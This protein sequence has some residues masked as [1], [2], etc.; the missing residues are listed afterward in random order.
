[1]ADRE[2]LL[3]AFCDGCYIT[4]LETRTLK[5]LNGKDIGC[6]GETI[7]LHEWPRVTFRGDILAVVLGICHCLGIFADDHIVVAPC[8]IRAAHDFTFQPA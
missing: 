5:V 4:W 8:I 1:M 3:S 7:P 6:F 2:G